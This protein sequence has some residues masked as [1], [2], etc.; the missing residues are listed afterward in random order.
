MSKHLICWMLNDPDPDYN[1]L[2][3]CFDAQTWKDK[4]LVVVDDDRG[5]PEDWVAWTGFAHPEY[6]EFLGTQRIT[7][8][9]NVLRRNLVL[10]TERWKACCS[11][12][13]PPDCALLSCPQHLWV[14]VQ[15]GN[16]FSD[17]SILASEEITKESLRWLKKVKELILSFDGG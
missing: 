4:E 16:R 1:G 12:Q 5:L 2:V 9:R 7:G 6:L 10:D 14:E 8:T 15:T 13:S 3:D 17:L 11:L